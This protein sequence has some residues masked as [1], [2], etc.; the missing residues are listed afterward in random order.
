VDYLTW[1]LARRSCDDESEIFIDAQD[2]TNAITYG[3]LVDL[4]QRIG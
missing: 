1:L 3:E 4:T 2:A